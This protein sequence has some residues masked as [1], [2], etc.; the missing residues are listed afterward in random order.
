MQINGINLSFEQQWHNFSFKEISQL[1]P[2]GKIYR[3][4]SSCHERKKYFQYPAAEKNLKERNIVSS[5]FLSGLFVVPLK[6]SLANALALVKRLKAY[7]RE[8]NLNV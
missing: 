5:G 7:A 2:R 8:Q 6:L 1:S 3:S 4:Q